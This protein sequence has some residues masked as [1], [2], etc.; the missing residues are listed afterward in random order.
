[1]ALHDFITRH[2]DVFVLGFFVIAA[3]T[4]FAA[5]FREAFRQ[6]KL[7][8]LDPP[9]ADELDA[10]RELRR[11]GLVNLGRDSAGARHFERETP[12]QRGDGRHGGGV[13]VYS[14]KLVKGWRQ[15]R[16]G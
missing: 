11:P 6:W 9:S 14:P 1:M 13:G 12:A 15:R 16:T 8:R 2:L 4:A 3:F 10:V 7:S 5:T